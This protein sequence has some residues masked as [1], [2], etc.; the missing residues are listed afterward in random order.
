MKTKDASASSTR[1]LLLWHRAC[2]QSYAAAATTTH[3]LLRTGILP[4]SSAEGTTIQYARTYGRMIR[5]RVV[6]TTVN[7]PPINQLNVIYSSAKTSKVT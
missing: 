3:E 5:T 1:A 4:R 7:K 6:L 2:S